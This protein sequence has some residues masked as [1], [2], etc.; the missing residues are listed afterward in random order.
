MNKWTKEQEEAI[1]FEGK[2]VIVSAGAGSG[3]TSVL[4]ERVLKKLKEGININELLVLTFTKSAAGEMISRI[5]KKIK[6]DE[7]LKEQLNLIDNSYI[8]TFD[9]FSLSLVKKYYYLLNISCDVNISDKLLMDIKRKEILDDIFDRYYKDGNIKFLDLIKTFYTKDDLEFKK[10]ILK[11]NDFLDKKYDKN[12]YLDHYLNDYYNENYIDNIIHDYKSLINEKLSELKKLY[13]YV[14]SIEDDK[15][16]SKYIDSLSMLINAKDYIDIKNNI[17]VT[18]P[19]RV[20]YSKEEKDEIKNIIEKLQELTQYESLDEIKDIYLNSKSYV[21]VIIDII[22]ELDYRLMSYKKKNNIY[23]FND[24]SKMAIGLL[25]KYPEIKD[26]L[27]YFY[28]EIMVD[29]Y[30]DTSDLQ[31]IFINLIS[32]NNL[33]MVGDIKQSIYRFRNANPQIFKDKYILY[34]KNDIGKKIDLLKNFRSRKEVIDAINKIFT[35]IMDLSIGGA[36]Y[37]KSH[38]MVFGNNMYLDNNTCDYNL[39]IYNY[40]DKSLLEFDRNVKEAYIILRDIEEK[41]KNKF[42]VIDSKTSEYRPCTYSDFCIIMDR[43]TDFLLY[44]KIF[45]SENIPIN[46]Y[47]DKKIDND[48]DLLIIKNILNFVIKVF[49]KDFSQEFRYLYTSIARSYLFE[50]TDNNIFNIFANFTFYDTDIY[51]KALNIS[52]KLNDLNCTLFLNSCLREFS[53]FDK[54]L[55][56]RNIKET[57]VRVKYL[58]DTATNLDK[59]GYTP[60]MF[61]DY[62]NKM[63]D[64]TNDIRIKIKNSNINAVKLMNI[65]MSKGL[66]FKICYYAGLYH[67]FNISDLNDKF[68][69]DKTYGIITPYY[70]NGVGNIFTKYLVKN[71]Y[72]YDEIS[73]K[74]RLLYVALTRCKEKLII[75][76]PLKDNKESLS[77]MVSNY[78][79]LNYRSFLDII[80]SVKESFKNEI[81]NISLDNLNI[82]NKYLT[83]ITKDYKKL[84]KSVPKII[85]KEQVIEKN[86]IEEKHFSKNNFDLKDINELKNIKK[87]LDI[88]YLFEMTDFKTNINNPFIK[89]FLAHKEFALIKDAK[90]YKEYEF[91]GI[92]DGT[93]YHG[94]IDLLLIYDDHADI[95]DY[96]L[97]NIDDKEY[98]KQ[99]DG[100]KKYISNIVLKDVH[101]YLYSINNDILKEI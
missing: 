43:K 55:K 91:S 88:H 22:K 10:N 50:E 21:E 80:S 42:L 51:Q 34:S 81:K 73:E 32:N 11:I 62:V 33:Y 9:S 60:Q 39:E 83:Y 95:I 74:I 71:N 17:T 3:K 77:T 30:Q 49:N 41:I 23:E 46:V 101:T 98:I 24:I 70:K 12:S 14:L 16:C 64:E 19:S 99:L 20:K 8:T 15:T 4:T 67:K 93:K 92:K 48:Y 66:E 2:S 1:N 6:N 28:K 26:E 79:R 38:E 54:M 5:R 61:V 87:G 84:K 13:H 29:E 100:Y 63:L 35:R 37:L 85:N 72:L 45:T 36:D 25:K 96:K 76:A 59:L 58:Y 18:L 97:D 86:V 31:E 27:K 57:I 89:R 7:S 75:V 94:I 40:D 52:K 69:I 44:E 53:F 78:K 68:Q 82:S 90:I 47:Q 65:H 56:Y